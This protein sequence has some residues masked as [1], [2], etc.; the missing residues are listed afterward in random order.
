[1]EE[2]KPAQL[3]VETAPEDLINKTIA[4][5]KL[6]KEENDRAERLLSR[7]I[8]GGKTEAGTAAPPQLDPAEKKRQEVMAFFKGSA[9]EGA[10]KRHG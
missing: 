3:P 8:L 6:L 5:A 4:A 7:Q 10:V 9:I 1:M 2:I